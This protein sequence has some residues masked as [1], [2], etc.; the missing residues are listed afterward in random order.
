MRFSSDALERLAA[1]GASW[2][3]RR[4][5]SQ[6]EHP[7]VSLAKSGVEPHRGFHRRLEIWQ[8][9]QFELNRDS[10]GESESRMGVGKR[11]PFIY[12]S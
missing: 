8:A 7:Q 6:E 2:G 12:C 5:H 11:S 3:G 1:S 9:Y 4:E 10:E